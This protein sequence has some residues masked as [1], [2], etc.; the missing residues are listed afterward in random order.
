MSAPLTVSVA[1]IV[2][3]F[4]ATVSPAGRPAWLV[5]SARVTATAAPIVASVPCEAVPSAVVD[6]SVFADDA[7]VT[8]PPEVS[9]SPGL[10]SVAREVV[11]ATTI[12]TAA[13]ALTLPSEVDALGVAVEPDDAPPFAALVA[14][15]LSRCDCTC[16]STPLPAP[17]PPP[18][19]DP[20]APFSG[21]PARGGA[22]GRGARAGAGRRERDR[23][24]RRDRPGG[25]RRHGVVRDHEGQAD[26]DARC[27]GTDHRGS[28]SG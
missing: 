18:V 10:S 17:P 12:A 20:A 6:A 28:G 27:S 16:W 13:A 24:G 19:P 4:A 21:A 5:T 2:S 25:R 9:V 11:V 15:A 26:A 22:R 7:S 14:S 1:E 8:S 23:A 3:P